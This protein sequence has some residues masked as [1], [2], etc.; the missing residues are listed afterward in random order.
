MV[1]LHPWFGCW[2]F[3]CRTVAALPELDTYSVDLY[4]L[5]NGAGWRDYAS[6]QGLARAVIA[7][8]EALGLAPCALVGNSMGGITGQ[9]LAAS[10]PELIDRLVLVGTGART[11]GVKPAFRQSLDEW[12]AGGEDRN[13]T[14]RLVDALLARRPADPR[15]FETFVEAVATAN[16]AFMGAVLN[17]AFALDLRPMLPRVTA[18]TLIVRGE[19]DAARTRVHVGEM[20]E[21]IKG[22]RAVELVGAGHSPQVDSALA[23]T[24]LMRD[25]LLGSEGRA[26]A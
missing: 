20:Q 3:W 14:T 23:F 8:I 19:H 7:M 24:P 1:L 25:F 13:F 12:I 17:A 16:K 2:Q 21:G 22:S 10:R 15:E 18:A 9:S 4:S 26:A 11:T 6:P 5:G